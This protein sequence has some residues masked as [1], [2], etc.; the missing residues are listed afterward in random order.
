MQRKRYKMNIKCDD[1]RRK[2]E[3]I[4]QE[5]DKIH[6]LEK[7]F[8]E[9][10]LQCSK[11]NNRYK[12]LVKNQEGTS[13]LP[14]SEREFAETLAIKKY[15]GYKK[16]ELEK[17]LLACDAY[18]R[19]ILSTEDKAEQLLYHPEYAKLLAKHFA[20][21]KEELAKW[22]SIPYEKCKK[23]EETLMIKGTQGKLLRSKSEAIIDMMLYKNRIPFRYEEKLV[24]EGI[25]IYPDFVI[26][27]PVT[28]EFYYWEHFGMM[29]EEDYRKHAC[30]KIK[31]YCDNGIIPSI[32]LITTYE[33]KE[34]P[35]SV[36]KVE[37]T[38]QEYFLM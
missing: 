34:H 33:T 24:L 5:L 36:E 4:N 2:K 22:Q 3:Q 15:Y 19:K 8:P 35:L 38:I 37:L 11:N 14:K 18:L 20:P 1:L 25:T 29:D 17:N 26:R 13:Y 30:N 9:G 7:K 31:L 16:Q 21:M 28:G 32:N 23:H 6:Q 27:H 10:E 12:W